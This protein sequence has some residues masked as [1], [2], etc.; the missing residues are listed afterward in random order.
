[1]FGSKFSKDLPMARNEILSTLESENKNESFSALTAKR[2]EALLCVLV[3]ILWRCVPPELDK[4]CVKICFKGNEPGSELVEI[5]EFKDL[6][7][8]VRDNCHKFNCI[9]LVY[10]AILTRGP[11]R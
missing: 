6:E 5:N 1:M 9:G 8:F 4:P 10:S 2:S 3:E 7:I 11:D